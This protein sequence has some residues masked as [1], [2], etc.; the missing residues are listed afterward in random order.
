MNRRLHVL[1]GVCVLLAL[2][3][4]VMLLDRRQPALVTQGGK[5]LHVV[6]SFSI[7]GDLVHQVGG[8][9]VV[10]TTLVGPEGD[11]HVYQPTPADARAL[12]SSDL[13]IVNGLGFE[14]WL[15][16]LVHASGYRGRIVVASAGIVPRQLDAATARASHAHST[17]DPHAWQS[18]PNVER[19]VTNIAA[20]LSSA[21]PNG[22]GIYRA[23][24]A[25]YQQ[26]L[27]ALH[28]QILQSIAALPPQRRTIVTSHDAFGY[29]AATYGLR[30]EAPQ[31]VSTEAE[32]SA[33]DVARLITQIRHDGAAALFV[34]DITDPR[35]LQQIARET[36]IRIGGTLYSDAL[37]H[38]DGPA[39]TYLDLMHH[40]LIAL[41]QALDPARSSP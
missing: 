9:R 38:R 13:V 25:A 19:Y 39:S 34:E 4:S 37:S 24:A 40:N 12:G 10:V 29:F 33:H 26:Q 32:A 21:D 11:A 15:D 27:R 35:L 7:L 30:F 2:A 31:G 18:V 1:L 23:N 6:A 17:L 3:A 16:R 41:V 8:Q 36:G 5:Q 28:A 20:A 14:G 22:A